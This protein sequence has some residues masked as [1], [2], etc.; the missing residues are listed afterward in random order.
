MWWKQAHLIIVIIGQPVFDTPS[1][2]LRLFARLLHHNNRSLHLGYS[3]HWLAA[4]VPA[5]ARRKFRLSMITSFEHAPVSISLDEGHIVACH[6]ITY[7]E[8]T[9]ERRS[10]IRRLDVCLPRLWIPCTGVSQA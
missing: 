1:E 5:L 10:F 6:N 8:A 7:A 4:V 2:V 9:Y 3:W